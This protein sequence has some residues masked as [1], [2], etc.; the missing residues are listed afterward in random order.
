MPR[1]QAQP[2]AQT[3]GDAL[4]PPRDSSI[5][6]GECFTE[7]LM[8]V[9]FCRSLLYDGLSGLRPGSDMPDDRRQYIALLCEAGVEP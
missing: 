1:P 6:A 3:Q 5:W 9:N 7:K 8:S 4:S 2:T